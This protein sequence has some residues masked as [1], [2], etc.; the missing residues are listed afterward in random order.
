MAQ[1]LV[2]ALKRHRDKPVLFL[3]HHADRRAADKISQYIQAF[4]ALGAGTGTA[5]GLL[6][7]NRPVLDWRFSALQF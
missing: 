7:L 1:V 4:D 6:A 5:V 3:R 2:G